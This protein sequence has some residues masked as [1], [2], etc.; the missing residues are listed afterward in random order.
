MYNNSTSLLI[1]SNSNIY[2]EK[3]SRM[4]I[5]KQIKITKQYDKYS[6]NNK[7]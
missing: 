1:L 4:N 3:I 7:N 2:F 6:W 5:N